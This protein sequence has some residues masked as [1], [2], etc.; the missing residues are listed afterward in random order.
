MK[1]SSTRPDRRQVTLWILSVVIVAS[2]LCSYIIIIRPPRQPPIPTP[3]PDVT[4]VSRATDTPPAATPTPT[5]TATPSP[6]P[7]GP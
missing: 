2:M 6:T 7:A 1:R 3:V 5:E 4:E